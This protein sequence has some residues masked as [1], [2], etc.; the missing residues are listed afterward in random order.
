M[1]SLSS[2]NTGGSRK[3]STLRKNINK[4]NS[5]SAIV[6]IF[7]REDIEYEQKLSQISVSFIHYYESTKEGILK[8]IKT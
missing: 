7:D 5:Y 1:K 2:L 4:F 6:D 8:S 3:F